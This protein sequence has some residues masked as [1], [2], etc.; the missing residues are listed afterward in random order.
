MV[1][2]QEKKDYDR[3]YYQKNKKEIDKRHRDYNEKNKEKCKARMKKNSRIHYERYRKEVIVKSARRNKIKTIEIKKKI[4]KLFGNKCANPF[5]INHGEFLSE[6]RCLQIDHV[7][8]GV[9][10]ERAKSKS[11]V[12]YYE[13]ILEKI[14]A[15]SKDYQLLCANC[16]WIKRTTNNEQNQWGMSNG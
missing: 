11:T 13:L 3:D 4:F 8:G 16:N 6:I 1:G 10:K 7:N 15:G 2:K 14:K 9:T 12:K 5:N